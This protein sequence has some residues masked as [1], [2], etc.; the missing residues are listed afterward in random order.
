MELP[1]WLIRIFQEDVWGVLRVPGLLDGGAAEHLPHDVPECLLE[2]LVG[3]HI[4]NWVQ[5]GVKVTCKSLER[6]HCQLTKLNAN[7]LT[8][9]QILWHSL[10]SDNKDK[11]NNRKCSLCNSRR[12]R[13]LFFDGIPNWLWLWLDM[14][15]KYPDLSR[16]VWP[17]QDED[18]GSSLHRWWWWG[19]RGRRGANRA[20]R[21]P[22]PPQESQRP[23]VPSPS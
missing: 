21:P 15:M 16:R 1:F 19:T 10:L 12:Q 5:R 23:C 22:S 8:N 6:S 11:G 9:W 2:L 4:D 7:C 3:H 18:R 14:D 13:R 17:P 20:G